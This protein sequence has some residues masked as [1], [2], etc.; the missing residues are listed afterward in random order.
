MRLGVD[1]DNTLVCYDAGFH[2][3]AVE[4]GLIPADLPVSKYAVRDYLRRG[5][6][7]EDWTELQGYLYG[8]RLDEAQAFPGALEFLARCLSEQVS[9]WIIS[10]KTRYP[11]RGP[12]Y[13]LHA[14]ARQWLAEHGLPADR[15]F[16]E[17]TKADKLARIAAL[18]CT[19]FVD[20]LPEFLAEPEF[21]AGVCRVLF[22]PHGQHEGETRFP[23]VASWAELGE[24][25][26][27]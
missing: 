10:H 6:R 3:V 1:F 18:G 13:D 4:R 5:D 17:L 16:L 27:R 24:L 21:P 8:A 2:R 12:Q 11:F 14:A 23:R 22:D 7:E 20:D 15:V 19:H 25:L 26:R 9:V